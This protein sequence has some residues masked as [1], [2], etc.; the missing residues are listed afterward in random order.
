[1][2]H[3]VQLVKKSIFLLLTGIVL[4]SILFA[5]TS[6]QPNPKTSANGRITI[7]TTSTI[8]T[9][10]PADAYD[11]F[12][13][14]IHFNTL[15]RLYTYKPGTTELVPQLAT[16]M[17]Q[18]SSDGLTYTI[19][20]RTG[21]KFHDR[22]D[23]TAEAMAFSLRRF[24]Q[25]KGAPSFLLSDI[26]KSVR[27]DNAANELIVTLKQP[28]PLFPKLLAFTGAG[29][30]SPLAYGGSGNKDFF[31]KQ[32]VGTG[33]YQLAQYVEG[34]LL[35]LDAFPDYWGQRP[36]NRGIDIQFLSSNANLLNAFKTGAVDVAFQTLSPTQIRNLET[37]AAQQ[38]W[39]VASNQGA[40]MLFMVLNVAQ[41]PLDNIKVRQAL[42]AAI[43]RPLL[44]E[45]VF[46]GQRVPV[47]SLIPATLS[48]YRPVFQ[49]LYG[50]GN[51]KLVRQLL[52]EAGYSDDRP[53]KISIWYTPKYAGNGDLVASTLKA[54][55]AK[56]VGKILQ[57]NLEKVDQTVAY[58]F[59]DKGAYSAFLLD[60]VPD[61][62]DP[63]NFTY[64]FLLCEE[65]DKNGCTKG[66]SQYF[67]SFYNNPEMNQLLA[68]QRLEQDPVKR[69]RLFAKIQDILGMDVPF[70]PLWQN[71]EY[72]F[73][74]P[75][76]KGVAIEPTQQLPYSSIHKT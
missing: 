46:Q 15:E 74:R 61:S 30:V 75:G 37:N 72:A 50:D 48:A 76:V 64:P 44:Q 10:D 20:V 65:A 40:T 55:I 56:S 58:A 5:C 31:P 57:I 39:T 52:T 42:A 1:M 34:N 18:V 68:Q 43:D 28:F 53:V 73:A 29:A 11:Q 3:P 12:T 26:I 36:A 63:D 67:G 71:R 21:V 38:G 69:D 7:G 62:F 60:W 33:P 17:P 35:R 45:R 54:A 25:L 41:P 27:S 14:N 19:P 6:T 59:L 51:A 49:K 66:G 16:A 70:I 9:L 22:T 4:V 32:I 23:F 2:R 13:G 8:K 47:Y 24:I